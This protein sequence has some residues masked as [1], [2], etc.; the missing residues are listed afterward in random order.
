MGNNFIICL[1]SLL[2]G[3]VIGSVS[4]QNE[5][6]TVQKEISKTLSSIETQNSLLF[7][8]IKRFE[9]EERHGGL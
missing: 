9:N 4:I 3:L 5:S 2:L 7:D 1:L 6:L 8:K